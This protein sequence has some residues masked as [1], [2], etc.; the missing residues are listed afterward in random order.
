MNFLTRDVILDKN[1]DILKKVTKLSF[2][3]E[4]CL[5]QN[6]PNP[7]NEQ[8][9]ISFIIGNDGY[10]ELKIYD[11]T[12][13]LVK[14]LSSGFMSKGNYRLIWIGTNEKGVKVSSGIYIVCLKGNN[15]FISKKMLYLK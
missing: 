6:F 3:G 4:N 1:E 7:F 11:I 5:M 13:K 9:H 12:G 15:F 8:T 10:F 14:T 2:T